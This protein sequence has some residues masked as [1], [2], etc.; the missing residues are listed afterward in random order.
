M[1]GSSRRVLIDTEISGRNWITLDLANRFVLH[2]IYLS[3]LPMR[4]WSWILLFPIGNCGTKQM[5][6]CCGYKFDFKNLKPIWN[7]G[8]KQM[9]TCCG[10]KF[11]FKNIK[12]LL[13]LYPSFQIITNLRQKKC[14]KKNN[15][16]LII[17]TW[18]HTFWTNVIKFLPVACT[19]LVAWAC[20]NI[21]VITIEFSCHRIGIIVDW[22]KH[23]DMCMRMAAL[24]DAGCRCHVIE[25]RVRNC[26]CHGLCLSLLDASY[27]DISTSISVR[28]TN[29]L[30]FF[31]L[32]FL[33]IAF[34]FGYAFIYVNVFFTC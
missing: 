30:I 34:S 10:Y 12:P 17:T 6:T 18:F 9:N 7:C 24:P 13:F 3:C 25:E 8:T 16:K 2:Y 29:L 19:H 21:F 4:R 26:L 22:H 5:N 14:L 20:L 15:N 32:I 27:D 11:D 23:R 1:D 33:S 31:A 28:L